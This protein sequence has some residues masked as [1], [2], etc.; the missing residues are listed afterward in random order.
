MPTLIWALILIRGPLLCSLT[1]DLCST[2]LIQK[3]WAKCRRSSK[4]KSC[5]ANTIPLQRRHTSRLQV[6]SGFVVQVV[7]CSWSIQFVLPQKRLSNNMLGFARWRCSS[8]TDDPVLFF[9]FSCSRYSIFTCTLTKPTV[10]SVRAGKHKQPWEYNIVF[11]SRTLNLENSLSCTITWTDMLLLRDLKLE[12][13]AGEFELTNF[14][15]CHSQISPAMSFLKM[16]FAYE[17]LRRLYWACLYLC[18]AWKQSYL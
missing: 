6:V 10:W 12:A 3:A 17:H 13:G 15:D 5:A 18:L 14:E 2:M 4:K 1:I 8:I 9:L 7:P 16:S 11:L